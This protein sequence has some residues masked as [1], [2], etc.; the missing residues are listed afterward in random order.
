MLKIRSIVLGVGLALGTT[1]V[2]W[3]SKPRWHDGFYFQ[4][5]IGAGYTRTSTELGLGDQTADLSVYGFGTTGSVWFGGT[6][7]PGLAIGG[8][9]FGSTAFAPNSKLSV[10]ST[11]LEGTNE[12]DTALSLGIVGPFA[13]WYF[14][15]HRGLHAQLLVGY[16]I[17]WIT[18]GGQT[19]SDNPSGV[20]LL[21]GLGYDFWVGHEWSIGFLGRF[22]YAPLSYEG[23]SY[24]T[25]APG[26]VATFTYH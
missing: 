14:N 23:Q 21:V 20:G 10:G 11:E 1:Q 3:A 5:T 2:A 7:V 8:G 17:A 6:P 22:A 24:P 9:T 19:S 16:G 15:P 18:S 13:D 12:A 25:M 26:L 4:G